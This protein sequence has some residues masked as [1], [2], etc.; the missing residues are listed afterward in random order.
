[1]ENSNFKPFANELKSQLPQILQEV[2]R[3]TSSDTEA[4]LMLMGAITTLSAAIPNVYGIYDK[5]VDFGESQS[6]NYYNHYN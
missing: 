1:M 5:N 2:V 6:Y 3:E 4:D